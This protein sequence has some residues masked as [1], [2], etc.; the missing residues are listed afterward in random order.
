MRRRRR[1]PH[2]SRRHFRGG[3]GEGRDAINGPCV[4]RCRPARLV[5]IATATANTVAATTTA[6]IAAIAS[7][8]RHPHR[9]HCTDA[10]QSSLPPLIA[11]V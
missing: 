9:R 8:H 6:V 7:R 3:G 10:S 5:T 11:N 4:L 2:L 1:R